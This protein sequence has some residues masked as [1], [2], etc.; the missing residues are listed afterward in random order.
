MAIQTEV[1]RSEGGFGVKQKVIIS[2]AYDIQN[3]N[4]LEVK[5]SEFTNC[6]RKDYV[7]RQQTNSASPIAILSLRSA[8][9]TPLTLSTS[10][11]NFITAHIIGTNANGS[12]YYAVKSE[13]TAAVD[14]IGNVTVVSELQTILKDSIPSGEGWSI[15]YYDSGAVNQFSYV[16]N[17][18]VAAGNILWT[19]H[20][21]V[22]TAD[23]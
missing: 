8:S 3:A 1:L 2:D 7:L 6:S 20:I 22:V 17:Q 15:A 9:I 16:A 12:G 5:N 11:V 21:Q 10:S 18:G 23:W 13:T 19:A 4:S 14:A